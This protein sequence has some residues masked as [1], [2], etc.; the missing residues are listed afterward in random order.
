M[1][2]DDAPLLDLRAPAGRRD[3]VLPELRPTDGWPVL[4]RSLA[5]VP[6]PSSPRVRPSPLGVHRPAIPVARPALSGLRSTTAQ[7]TAMAQGP[8][9]VSPDAA[10][11]TACR[12]EPG[13]ESLQ[14]VTSCVA[15]P[16]ICAGMARARTTPPNSSDPAST[17]RRLLRRGI[18][19]VRS[20][21]ARRIPLLICQE[22]SPGPSEVPITVP[23]PF[24]ANHSLWQQESR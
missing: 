19:L 20:T 22:P 6:S 11:S 9:T 16:A 24:A 17:A 21:A 15:A 3:P 7:Q 23:T 14:F 1:R 5:G 2:G 10:A 8:F 12:N 13:P 18:P 4:V